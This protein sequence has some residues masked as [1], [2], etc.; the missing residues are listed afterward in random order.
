MIFAL[1]LTFSRSALFAGILGAFLYFYRAKPPRALLWI[2]GISLALGCLLF[3]E[4]MVQRGG[5][6]NYNGFSANSDSIRVEQNQ[7][8]L[9]MIVRHPLFGVGYQQFT[10][11]P[12]FND[13]SSAEAI[14]MVHNSLL[15]VGAESGILALICLC[16]F[17]WT[18]LRCG[19]RADSEIEAC[20]FAVGV[21]F[22]LI[23]NSDFYP[24]VF[25]YAKM[26]LFLMLGLMMAQAQ[27][28]G[29]FLDRGYGD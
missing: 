22:C 19:W 16:V 10:Y 11:T 26:S 1:L 25:Q 2:A 23:A 4:Q 27:E 20:G 8:A 5:I 13:F 14:T 6:F 21:A 17:F 9:T 18:A 3:G 12:E 24:Y 7:V 29:A 28:L 15:L